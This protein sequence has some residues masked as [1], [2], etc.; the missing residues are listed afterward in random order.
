MSSTGSRSAAS[1][2]KNFT[3]IL[4]P[5]HYKARLGI[6]PSTSKSLM[7]AQIFEETVAAPILMAAAQ[8]M[9]QAADHWGLQ[10]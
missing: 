4:N 6:M 3:T 7:G 2:G 1:L 5:L 8:S 10:G 9:P